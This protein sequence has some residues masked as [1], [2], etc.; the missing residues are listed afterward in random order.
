MDFMQAQLHKNY[1]LKS[2]RKRIS[3]QEQNEESI[4]R[5]QTP[6]SLANKGKKKLEESSP[7][8]A[9]ASTSTK[10]EVDPPKNEKSPYITLNL[11]NHPKE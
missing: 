10:Q 4:P 3:V 5:E 9:T 1:D 8:K 11:P 2:S 7:H 6:P